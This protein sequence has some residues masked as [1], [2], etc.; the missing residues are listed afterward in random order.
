M[1]SL[2][3]DLSTIPPPNLSI[4]L[5]ELTNWEEES[6]TRSYPN[7]RSSFVLTRPSS[8]NLVVIL[9]PSG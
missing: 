3:G 2:S 6:Y 4:Q 1:F 8:V 7:T 9:P 5:I